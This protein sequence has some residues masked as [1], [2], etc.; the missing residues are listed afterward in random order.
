MDD[1]KVV[2]VKLYRVGE[3]NIKTL[4]TINDLYVLYLL[5]TYNIII[6]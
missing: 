2:K 5:Q 1:K 3:L 4:T 6:H